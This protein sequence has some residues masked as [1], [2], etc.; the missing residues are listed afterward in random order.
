MSHWL[1]PANT[2]F[3]DVFAALSN[4][5][6]VWPMNSKVDVGDTVFLYLAAPHKKIGFVCDVTSINIPESVVSKNTSPYIKGEKK[7]APTG[8]AFMLLG[9][10]RDVSSDDSDRFSY[11]KLKHNGLNGMLM[12]P[13]KLENN[14]PLF[15][16]I[17]IQNC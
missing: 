12:G 15:H 3:Y 17:K 8:K 4:A 10:I 16:Y 1:Y 2:K 14:Q 7:D 9:N 6:A 13:R 5:E 11:Q